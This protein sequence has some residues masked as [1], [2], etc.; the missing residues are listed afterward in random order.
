MGYVIQRH[1]PPQPAWLSPNP[2]DLYGYAA[3]AR[4]RPALADAV[5][6][7][8][9]VTVLGTV[10]DEAIAFERSWHVWSRQTGVAPDAVD[11]LVLDDG[12]TDDIVEV[13][14]RARA[15]SEFGARIRYARMRPPG[16]P[17]QR[18][19][20]LA[21]NSGVRHLVRTPL[22]MI[23]WWD[24]IP[25]S[26]DHLARLIAPHRKLAGIATSA[27]SR[28]IGGSS[29]M[30]EMTPDELA[31]TLALVDWRADPTSLDRVA[32]RIGGH[33]VPGDASESSGLVIP[34]AEFEAL[35]GFDERYR[36]RAGY[37]NVEFFRRAMQS[38]LQIVFPG[39]QNYHQS[40]PANR[41]KDHGWLDDP[42]VMRNGGADWGIAA[43][44]EV[45]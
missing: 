43:P 29:S 7:V 18:S 20:T 30:H 38:G 22:V 16:A 12:S 4:T 11:F 24:R 8:P 1:M 15:G 10:R 40:H 2:P 14:R 31:A 34:V 28:H 23:Q 39:V 26:F 13:V 36:E 44:I 41:V 3:P 33:C 19:C 32:G 17:E 37:V 6:G 9:L 45:W 27:V 42:R 21:F 35:G 5:P 25:G